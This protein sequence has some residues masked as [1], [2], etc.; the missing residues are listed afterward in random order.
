M[1]NKKHTIILVLSLIFLLNCYQSIN[2]YSEGKQDY[3]FTKM[4]D[5]EDG[6]SM[7]Y[8]ISGEDEHSFKVELKNVNNENLYSVSGESEGYYKNKVLLTGEHELCFYPLRRSENTISFD[9]NGDSE[10]GNMLNI[11]NGEEIT[12]LRNSI[13]SIL[14]TFEMIENNTKYIIERQTT[15]SESK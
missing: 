6:I 8:Y 12:Q 7:S 11:A 10:G 1:V 3:C 14:S 4:F 2:F 9:F 13:F 15:H 5:Q